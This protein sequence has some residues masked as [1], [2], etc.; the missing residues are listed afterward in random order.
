MPYYRVFLDDETVAFTA[1]WGSGP[2]PRVGD[3]FELDL[4]NPHVSVKRGSMICEPEG[5]WSLDVVD[6]EEEN[7]QLVVVA[8]S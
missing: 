4:N 1:H 5:R 6:L 3:Q 2:L 7:G 8:M